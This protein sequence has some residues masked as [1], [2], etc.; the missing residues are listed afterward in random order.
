MAAHKLSLCLKAMTV[1]HLVLKSA[2]KILRLGFVL[3]YNC[4]MVRNGKIASDLHHLAFGLYQ[5]FNYIMK[6]IKIIRTRIII[7]IIILQSHRLD[8]KKLNEKSYQSVENT[9]YKLIPKP[10]L[11]CTTLSRSISDH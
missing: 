8:L 7:I 10:E 3:S 9:S 4:V 5:L 6:I 1:K 2:L 11:L